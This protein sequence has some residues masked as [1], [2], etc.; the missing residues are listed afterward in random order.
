MGTQA[1]VVV[2]VDE[3]GRGPL[4]GPVVAGACIEMPAL[5]AHPLIK[6]SKALTPEE[7]EEAFAWIVAHCTY[8]FGIADH[9]CIDAEGILGATERAMQQAV[10]MIAEQTTPTFLI[11]D[12]RD[13]FWFDYPHTSIIDGDALEPAIAAASIVAKV[14]RDRFMVELAAQYPQYGFE[15]HK[16][17]AT[18][19]H[20]EMI[21][22]HGPCS[23]HRKKFIRNLLS[24]SAA[25]TAK[26]T[27]P[28]R[29]AAR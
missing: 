16:G 21:L 27:P 15:I 26:A 6:D 1:S 24:A 3:A 17:Y 5:R 2:G 25:S 12:G 23:I 20:Q 13:K 19:L 11:V 18:P 14:T 9:A 8:G 28:R 10:A 29:R 4:A 22:K 7:R